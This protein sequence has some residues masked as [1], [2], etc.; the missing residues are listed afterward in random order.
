MVAVLGKGILAHTRSK[1]EKKRRER[2]HRAMSRG[3]NQVRSA[4]KQRDHL[5]VQELRAGLGEIK[6]TDG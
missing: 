5:R 2:K 1:V 3:V 4:D 6:A